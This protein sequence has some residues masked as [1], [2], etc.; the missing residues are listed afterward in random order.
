MVRVYALL[1]IH[2]NVYF[3]ALILMSL[4]KPGSLIIILKAIRI[5]NCTNLYYCC[6][7]LKLTFLLKS[8]PFS[9]LRIGSLKFASLHGFFTKFIFVE[10]QRC[11][12]QLENWIGQHYAPNPE[13]E[14]MFKH[15]ALDRIWLGGLVNPAALMTSLKHE[16]ASSCECSIENV[17]L[18]V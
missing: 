3:S 10:F 13:Q 17:S 18:L 1:V 9:G 7:H 14:L 16:K 11:H 5:C 2:C 12:K 8:K 6:W 4:K 15:G